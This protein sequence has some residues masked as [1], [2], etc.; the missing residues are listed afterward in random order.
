MRK[1]NKLNIYLNKFRMK[2]IMKFSV[3]VHNKIV[4]ERLTGTINFKE[5]MKYEESKNIILNQVA[6]YCIC[7]DIRGANFNFSKNER[8]IVYNLLKEQSLHMKDFCKC[9][10]ITETPGEVVESTLLIR[11]IEDTSSMNLKV[12]STTSAAHGWLNII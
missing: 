11:E 10:I 4:Y 12:F 8:N 6:S 5:Y 1:I 7:S 3:D 2:Q 9:A